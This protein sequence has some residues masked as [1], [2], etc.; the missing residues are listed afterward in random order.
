MGFDFMIRNLV[1]ALWTIAY[2]LSFSQQKSKGM[3]TGCPY[4]ELVTIFRFIFTCF[5]CELVAACRNNLHLCSFLGEHPIHVMI[6]LML[7]CV[8]VIYSGVL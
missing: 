2:L 8:C 3:V 5:Y 7:A 4:C 6:S 1:T